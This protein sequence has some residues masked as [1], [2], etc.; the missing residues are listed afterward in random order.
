MKRPIKN[1]F[2]L[3]TALG[4]SLLLNLIQLK[5][6]TL[7]LSKE[8][9][10]LFF[11]GAGVSL[12]VYAILGL[13]FPLIFSRYIPYY[14]ARGEES[15]IKTL[16]TL[17]I[18]PTIILTPLI[19]LFFM[20]VKKIFP[21]KVSDVLPVALLSYLFPSLLTLTAGYFTG[22]RKM[23]ISALYSTLHFFPFVFL[24]YI[25][26]GR[27][28]VVM[29]YLFL[30]LSSLPVFIS[31]LFLVKPSIQNYRTV[32]S[33]I[34]GYLA[35][36]SLSSFI[37]PVFQYG[38]RILIASFFPLEALGLFMVARRVDQLV[39]RFM[40][41]PLSA[42]APEVSYSWEKLVDNTKFVENFILFR[43]AYLFLS[44]S[45]FF[46]LSLLG[47]PVILLISSSSYL[48]AYP[49]LVILLLAIILS[50]LYTPYNLYARSMGEM[51]L[52]F[53][54]DLTWA[55]MY[56]ISF[57]LL[58]KILKLYGAALSMVSASFFAFLFTYTYVRP[59]LRGLPRLDSKKTFISFLFVLIGLYG[60][61]RGIYV[62]IWVIFVIYLAISIPEVIRF[63][64]RLKF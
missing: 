58:A 28:T 21:G 47:K 35:F 26:R 20:G 43:D 31:A 11:A 13:R 60:A 64:K 23:H 34:K 53:L 46:L 38:D 56:F 32:L 54:A 50:A 59:R 44:V 12:S 8:D 41:V 48:D 24:L 27:L 52:F 17:A 62:Y 16:Y 37:T 18:L 15:K 55:I 61:L 63:L 10:G 7:F 22:L 9:V 3:Y 5:I 40:Y 25:A 45:A 19:V 57:P 2:Y 51:K 1:T 33:D 6:L 4:F 49:Y 42:F 36:T 29:A 14:E 39:R 30:L